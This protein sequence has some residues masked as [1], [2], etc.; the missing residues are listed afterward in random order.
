MTDRLHREATPEVA[1]T[2]AHQSPAL[3]TV[4]PSIAGVQRVFL[5]IAA[6]GVALHG[7]CALAGTHP[8]LVDDW[9]YCG[10]YVIA[11]AACARRGYLGDARR[12]WTVAALGVL[13]WGG[14]EVVFRLAQGDPHAWYPGASQTMLFV[15]FTLAYVT[16]GL[17]A[18]ERV[19][20]FDPVLALDGILAGL[21][22][23]ALAAVLL[24]PALGASSREPN[25]P[26]EVFLIGAL[27][28]L[29]FV[30][31]VLGMTGWRPGPAWG[32]IATGIAVNVAGDGWLVHLASH[33]DFR[34]GSVADTAFVASA[35]MLGLASFHPTS[36]AAVPHGPARRLPIPLISAVAAL[37]V[38]IAGLTGGAGGL[39]AGL[40]VAALAVMI[41]RMTVAL[42]LLESSRRQALVDELT[43]LGNRRM[44]VRDLARRL[45]PGTEPEPFLLGLFDLDGFKRYN[46]T[47]G[48]LSGDALLVRLAERLSDA[49]GIDSAY[50]M[51]G[52]EFCVIVEAQGAGATEA[53][54]GAQRALSEHGDGFAITSS[55][56][57]VSCPAETRTVAEAL[58]TA[59]AR[60]YVAKSGRA[61]DQAQTRDAVLK[62]LQERDPTLFEH[63]RAVAVIAVRVARR[64]RLDD[65]SVQ[66]VGRAAELHDIGKIAIPDAI[67]HKAG[68]LD[69]NERLFMRQYPIVGQRILR[70][71][72]A[73]APIAPLVRSLHERWDGHGYP[74]GLRGTEVAIGARIIS[75]CDAYHSMRSHHPY[76]EART[77]AEALDELRRCSGTQFDP[78]VVDALS[79]ELAGSPLDDES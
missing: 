15:G 44:L 27:V 12:A 57:T 18:R 64:L 61:L 70:S 50:R 59:D 4:L 31:T 71:A 49:V 28:G 34:R 16:L 73:L 45:A 21:A 37:G 5:P 65:V 30:V 33:G 66:Q 47:F 58:R 24:F 11:A 46:D 22:A 2:S 7:I 35:L 56:G 77:K 74:D 52:D 13:V 55:S 69:A 1:L 19:R 41:A 10:L 51:G 63:M 14:A 32:L 68:A 67:L 6:F 48:H 42:E 29:F 39:A 72:P 26:A 8:P 79:A 54:I 40:A 20:R 53:L 23:A 36:H 17:L 38:L 43:G 9:L 60:M 75:V 3:S 25:A 78:D 76:R 62:M